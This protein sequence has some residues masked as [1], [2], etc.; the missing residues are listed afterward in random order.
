M[1]TVASQAEV[2]L[3]PVGKSHSTVQELREV[4]PVFFTVQLPP[5]PVPQSEVLAKVAVALV[6]AWAGLARPTR[7]ARGSARV[8][9]SAAALCLKRMCASLYGDV[10]EGMTEPHARSAARIERSGP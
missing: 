5:K 6:A 4:V 8:A 10:V 7:P 9:A 1:V 2:T 3:V